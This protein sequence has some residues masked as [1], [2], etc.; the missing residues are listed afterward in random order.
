MTFNKCYVLVQGVLNPSKSRQILIL[1]FQIILKLQVSWLRTETHTEYSMYDIEIREYVGLRY[2]DRYL[3]P[4][5]YFLAFMQDFIVVN[6][7][8]TACIHTYMYV[9]IMEWEKAGVSVLCV[10]F[11]T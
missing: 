4:A 11:A 5:T 9:H 6:N 10:Q 2:I 3:V 8:Y 7:L 1:I